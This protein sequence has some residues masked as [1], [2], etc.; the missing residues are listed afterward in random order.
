MTQTV[1]ATSRTN[2]CTDSALLA[3]RPQVTFILEHNGLLPI[4][5]M[6]N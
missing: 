5:C 2:Y 6:S 3:E 1:Y 4:R